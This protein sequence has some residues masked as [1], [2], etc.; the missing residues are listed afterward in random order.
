MPGSGRS[1][2]AAAL[3]AALALAACKQEPVAPPPTGVGGLAVDSTFPAEGALDAPYVGP[4]YVYFDR[5]L[6][7]STVSTQTVGVVVGAI[8]L[9]GRVSYDEARHAARLDLAVAPDVD[10]QGV[11]TIAVRGAGGEGL[12]SNFTWN[13]HARATSRQVIDPASAS[14]SGPVVAVDGAGVV[15][16]A[17]L[18]S[19]AGTIRYARCASDCTVAAQ[20]TLTT[21]ASNPGT[22]SRLDLV[23]SPAGEPALA[24]YVGGIGALAVSTCGGGCESAGAWQTVVLDDAIGD[25]GYAPSLGRASDGTLHVLYQQRTVEDVRYVTCA[26]GCGS[27]AGWSAPITLDDGVGRGRASDLVVTSSG[28][29]DAAW[30]SDDDQL[31]VYGACAAACATIGSWTVNALVSTS[32]AADRLSLGITADD[33]PVVLFGVSD[34]VAVGVCVSVSCASDVSWT[35]VGPLLS[36]IADHAR[37]SLAVDPSGR[38]HGVY[39]TQGGLVRY[40]SCTSSCNVTA[41]QWVAGTFDSGGDVVDAAV[42]LDPSGEPLVLARGRTGGVVV[43]R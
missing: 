18:D 10:Y 21:V 8:T 5:A 35:F 38:L 4:F 11:A 15:H 30:I 24:Y 3:A 40:L 19:I 9:P 28:G 14:G 26:A 12:D 7:P 23:V 42:A 16:A 6:D 36:D 22:D 39:A 33:Q 2:P 43:V 27:A 13:F 17:Y 1:I 41:A 37:P 34:F 29:V 31:I 32:G 20:W 25:A